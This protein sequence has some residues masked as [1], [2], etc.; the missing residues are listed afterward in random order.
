MTETEIPP[1]MRVDY[2][3]ADAAS[4][5]RSLQGKACCKRQFYVSPIGCSWPLFSWIVEGLATTRLHSRSDTTPWCHSLRWRCFATPFPTML[6]HLKIYTL[7]SP[8]IL[9]GFAS[10]CF[11]VRL[12][13]LV[14]FWVRAQA[15]IEPRSGVEHCETES[16]R[17]LRSGWH[18]RNYALQE[19]MSLV[20]SVVAGKIDKA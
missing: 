5:R 15:R 20:N 13:P 3:Y 7:H 10:H 11:A 18:G 2:Y 8:E 12:R 4:L 9:L 19:N 16:P 17:G 1:A 6:F 14:S